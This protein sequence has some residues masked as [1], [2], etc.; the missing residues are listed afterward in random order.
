M[1]GRLGCSLKKP[2]LA[3][4]RYCILLHSF[5]TEAEK[6]VDRGRQDSSDLLTDTQGQSVVGRCKLLSFS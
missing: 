4:I 6:Q 2:L 3:K 1:I 5:I